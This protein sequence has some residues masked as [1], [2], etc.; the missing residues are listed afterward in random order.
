ML[1][2]CFKNRKEYLQV[3]EWLTNYSH[4]VFDFHDK[5]EFIE[6]AIGRDTA[7]DFAKKIFTKSGLEN[8]TVIY[9]FTEEIFE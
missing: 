3:C 1:K 4:I 2:I 8:P 5:N 6:V 7:I 9:Y